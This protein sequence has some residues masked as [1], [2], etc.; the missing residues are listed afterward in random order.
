M[1]ES[2]M[3]VNQAPPRQAEIPGRTSGVSQSNGNDLARLL[4]QWNNTQVQYPSDKCVHELVEAQ[5]EHAFQST[6]VVQGEQRLTYQELNEGANQ[7]AHYLRNK[8]VGPDVAV[9][10]CLHRSPELM[11]ALLGVLK[12]GGAC[13]PLDPDYPRERLTYML[14]D[15]GAPVLITTASLR[16][17]LGSIPSEVVL[18]EP[19]LEI[20]AGQ[21]KDNPSANTTPENLAYVIYTSGSTGK[22]RG[23]LL[24]HRGLVN[25][26]VA[27]VKLYG[28]EPK[29]RVLQFA[30]IS[31]DIAIEETWPTWIAG[32]TLI[33]R[34]QQMMGGSEFLRWIRQQRVTVLDLPTAYWHELVRE[35][36]ESG[37][38]VPESLRMVIVG[39]EKASSAAYNSWLKS[40]GHRSRWINTYGPTEAS[41]IATSY[42]PDRSLPVPE[43]LPIGRPI[44]NTKIHILDASLQPVPIG[45]P[46]ELHIGGP[47]LAR[48]YLNRPEMTQAKFIANPKKDEPGS[49]LYKTGDL[50][51]FL[52]NGEI[53]FIGRVDFQ[54][55]IRGYR[56]ELGEIESALQKCPGVRECVVIAREENNDKRLVAYV[57]ASLERVPTISELRNL[58]KKELPEYMVPADFMFL[59]ALPLTVNGKVNR[60][61]LPA[62]EPSSASESRERVA[63]RDAVESQMVKIWEQVLGKRSIGIRDNFFELGG[64]SLLAIRLMGRVEKAFG[65]DLPLT[66]LVQGQ[67]VE[68]FAELVR[69]DASSEM[70]SSMIPLQ[71]EGSKPPFF[72]VHGLGGT[73][74]RFH[75]LAR[76]M[77][78]DQPFYGIQAVGLNGTQPCLNRV[79]DMTAHYLEQLIG[80]QPEGPYFLGGYSFGGLVALEM[81]RCLIAKGQVVALLAMVD[82]YPG[83][84]KSTGSLVG[85]FFSLSTRQKLA[86]LQKRIKRYRKGIKR[87]IDMLRMPQELKDVRES[88]A[89]AEERYV[90]QTYPGKIV[91]FRASEKALRGLDDPQG[92]WSQYAAG[93][94]EI[95]EIDADHGNI[96]NEP[97]V[98]HLASA[99]RAALELSQSQSSEPQLVSLS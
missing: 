86:Y 17:E 89:V 21:S 37:Q 77:V 57:V 32:A 41:V 59:K 13:L 52:P 6:A 66:A 30:S 33:I 24:T 46:G 75:E 65:K 48:G 29:D 80:I 61:A 60:K 84:P 91:L 56:I 99:M 36:A 94:L 96:L 14:E 28:I 85:K 78:P 67:T 54:V 25:H 26:H 95:H 76:R 98:R 73:V 97:Q 51:R 20:L 45:T 68:R 22:P 19:G 90:P 71:A 4:A 53:E 3:G 31:F 74:L 81:A 44:A 39:G 58:L 47:G 42:E 50:A 8:G 70:W 7:L 49:R 64:N 72:F 69:Q 38:S 5:V 62:P 82:T 18:L 2:S 15:S 9:G 88:C 55:K 83:A 63:P 92:G 27:A 43:N 16:A 40:G 10:I 79:E 11:I 12:A 87:R 35:V 1:M 93:G 23:V 34:N